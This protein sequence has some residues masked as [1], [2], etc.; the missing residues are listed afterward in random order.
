M[1]QDNTAQA[2]T[3]EKSCKLIFWML[4]FHPGILPLGYDWVGLAV[5]QQQCCS[6]CIIFI[7]FDTSTSRRGPTWISICVDFPLQYVI[8]KYF[9]T[10][11]Q[12]FEI[13]KIY[14]KSV[15]RCQIWCFCFIFE[16]NWCIM[17]I[18]DPLLIHPPNVHFTILRSQLC[19]W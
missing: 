5:E 12:S 3:E 7:F 14:E 6:C 8:L 9:A 4:I 13:D 18:C 19:L 2:E 10:T 1:E 17:V 15:F 11:Y 16:V